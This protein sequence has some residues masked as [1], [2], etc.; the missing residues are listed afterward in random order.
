MKASMNIWMKA[1]LIAVVALTA[2]AC[3]IWIVSRP[4]VPVGAS[5]SGESGSPSFEVRVEK[6]R[7]DRF[8]FGILPSRLEEKL[9]GGGELRFGHASG[10]AQVGRVGR[11]RVE[12][13][14]DGW[15]LIVEADGMGG[16]APGTHLV[17]PIEIAE[18]RRTLRCRPADRPTGHLH[19]A[20][21]AGS[22]ELDGSFMVELAACVNAETGKI[23]DTEAG[24]NPGEAWPSEPL[25]VRGSFAGLPHASR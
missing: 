21:R 20:E 19:A 7:M 16:I 22:G 13:R 11:D 24:G 9:L 6:P 2:L 10:G 5:T 4:D 18:V 15:E 17:F 14:A 25:T 8:L 1:S 23:I 3:L 12:L